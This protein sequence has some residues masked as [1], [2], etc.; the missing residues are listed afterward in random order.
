MYVYKVPPQAIEPQ[1]KCT[2]KTG[3][4]Q[5]FQSLFKVLFQILD[6]GLLQRLKWS[7]IVVDRSTGRGVSK[8][9]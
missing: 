3:L 8:E 2:E 4:W 9:V 7:D 5:S 1:L 6:T